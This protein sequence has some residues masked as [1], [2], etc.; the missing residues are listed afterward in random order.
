VPL[1]PVSELGLVDITD[2][3]ARDNRTATGG[4]SR[5]RPSRGR[6]ASKAKP[7]STT[8]AA[9]K[10]SDGASVRRPRNVPSTRT[11]KTKGAD[12]PASRGSKPR[13]TSVSTTSSDSSPPRSKAATETGSGG[14]SRTAATVTPKRPIGSAGS[15]HAARTAPRQTSGAPRTDRHAASRDGRRP[16]NTA[17]PGRTKASS[18]AKIRIYAF[19]GA[20]LVAG[21]VLVARAALRR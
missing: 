8:P 11:D 1:R 9:A 18:A 6:V 2:V 4:Q 21:G 14:T 3:P 16:R 5:S 19:A 15:T 13:R 20:S 7:D 17:R 10:K 12:P